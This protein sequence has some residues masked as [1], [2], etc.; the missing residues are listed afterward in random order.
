MNYPFLLPFRIGKRLCCP[1]DGRIY[2][3]NDSISAVYHILI[4]AD[5]AVLIGRTFQGWNDNIIKP[6]VVLFF[7]AVQLRLIVRHNEVDPDRRI[8]PL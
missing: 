6:C 1:A 7:V 4:C 5:N 8:L 3:G 2:I